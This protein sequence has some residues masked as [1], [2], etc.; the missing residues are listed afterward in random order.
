MAMLDSNVLIRYLTQDDPGLAAR[1]L[2]LLEQVEEGS[3]SVVLIEGV[4]VETVSSACVQ[5]PIQREPRGD[6]DTLA[7]HHS[8]RPRGAD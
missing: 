6:P 7:L 3:R 5:A 8:S 1:A 4:L 2:A